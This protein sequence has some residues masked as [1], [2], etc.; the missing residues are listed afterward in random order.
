MRTTYTGITKFLSPETKKSQADY[1][2]AKFFCDSIKSSRLLTNAQK[3]RL[4]KQ[5]TSGD[6]TGA[7]KEYEAILRAHGYGK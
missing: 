4:W 3:H 1:V 2:R 7:R 5:A 6:L